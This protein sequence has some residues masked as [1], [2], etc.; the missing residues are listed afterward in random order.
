[1]SVMGRPALREHGNWMSWTGLALLCAWPLAAQPGSRLETLQDQPPRFERITD[2]DGLSQ[3]SVWAILQDRRGFLWFGTGDG[4]N[5][6]DGQEIEVFTFDPDD[7]NSLSGETVS[8][9]CEGRSGAL[10]VATTEGLNR[11]DR[12]PA[13][14]SARRD[15]GDPALR[16]R[17][18]HYR[19][20]PE[21]GL[22]HRVVEA[23]EEDR[24]GKLWIGTGGGLD[25][26]DPATGTWIHY[27]YDPED[28][29]SLGHDTVFALFEDRAGAL[30]V[31][32]R[33]G[34]G[35]LD[36]GQ[37]SGGF[38]HFRH[39]PD[40]PGSLGVGAVRAVLE[41]RSSNLWIGTNGGL[42]RFDRQRQSF[43]SYRHDP[44]DPASLGPGAVLSLV[45]DR[46]GNLWI[47]T[48]GGGLAR[49]R[50]GSGPAG[51]G[52]A[53][54]MHSRH[55]P[56][57][58]ASLSHDDVTALLVDRRGALWVGTWA[59]GVN[60]F[61]P[62][63]GR[64]E[65][66]RHDPADAASLDRDVVGSVYEDRSGALWVGT[67]AG[68][69]RLDPGPP[70]AEP[71]H[72][73]RFV[74]H[75]LGPP[76]VDGGD[77]RSLSQD[78]VTA[79]TE[80]REGNLWAGTYG[81]GIHR[82]D[83]QSFTSYRHDPAD[84]GSLADDG[85]L[86]VLEDRSGALWVGTFGGLDRYAGPG[87]GFVH[88][89]HDPRDPA[90]P[91]DKVVRC[92]Y[93]DDA[94]AL[95]I[96]A[97][98]GLYRLDPAREG[99]TDYR[100][101]PNDPSSLS[102]D[103]VLAI[104]QDRD[105]GLWLGTEGGGLNRLS[106]DQVD[107]GRPIFA[108]VTMADGLPN[109][110]VSGIL[111]DDDRRLWLSTNRGLCRYDPATGS[112][113]SYDLDD[114][115]QGFEFTQTA[116]HR[117]ADGTMYF[118]GVYGLTYFHPGRFAAT[119]P[120]PP[121]ALT[122]FRVFE[123]QIAG[124]LATPELEAVELG[125][126]QNF[127]SFEFAALSYT[128]PDKS[129]YAY[130]LEGLDKGWIDAGSR[131]YAS[132]T[133]VPPGDYLFRIKAANRD[134]IWNEEGASLRITIRP[135]FWATWWFRGAGLVALAGLLWTAHRMRLKVLEQRAE[136]EKAM[137]RKRLIERLQEKN[138]ELE[139][140]TYTVSHDLKSP[141]VT[142]QG[143]LGFLERDVAA[144]AIDPGAAERV[145]GDVGRIRGAASKMQRL[146]DD[147][148]ELSRVGR[149]ANPSQ[150][151]ALVALAGEVRELLAGPIATRGAEVVIDPALP[152]VRGDRTRL[153]QLLQNL[154]Q[155]ALQYM[156]DQP[157]PRVE[158]GTRPCEDGEG[159]EIFV[160]DNGA[161]IAP[162]HQEKIF[163][164]FQR[165]D[166]GTGGT[167]VGLTLVKRIAEV[168]GGRIRVESEGVGHGSTFCFTLP[169]S[170][171]GSLATDGEAEA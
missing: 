83:G 135:P 131:R 143:F 77:A 113:T 43:E 167:G 107:A 138:T 59:G 156:G 76:A 84:P 94:G 154:M 160:R 153:H 64:F 144:A 8:A 163:E 57:D 136:R 36:L 171:S 150:D 10:W 123:R 96:G 169:G 4:L 68:L 58:P 137:E 106:P 111:E 28:S 155:N 30:W 53:R 21:R 35:R 51:R 122:D 162:E 60:R 61:D 159:E 26:L 128:R 11:I 166:A 20:D 126:R 19:R 115:L 133:S 118:G 103:F 92:L 12:L 149:E 69:D 31:G 116:Y 125:P 23:L 164:L 47:G 148:L 66:Y 25:R 29:A 97:M 78:I 147:L 130:R 62:D 71:P 41:D 39:Q 15:P 54:F 1:M 6:Y 49:L 141:L 95:W 108:R 63:L 32:T 140:F 91:G 112:V 17:I 98:E 88:H 104:H 168:H 74:H 101:D 87:R 121:V 90:S 161:G 120:P 132:Y 22:S 56:A 79:I 5:R 100:H 129:R 67:A 170:S 93:E 114:G 44:R 158:V 142:I 40:D 42:S 3:V 89:G 55:D 18:T 2:R 109:N 50:P 27:R 7:A 37:S 80:D 99:F 16:H 45:E 48:E 146:I 85:I 102:H 145:A 165:L 86:A 134:G 33:A 9:L 82:F 65:T 75:R 14:D 117:G 72:R 151:V 38:T 46:H 157:A 24:S 52:P 127:F 119:S 70:A 124:P 34:L 105:G 13:G 152:V 139:R 110:H 81:S 73:G